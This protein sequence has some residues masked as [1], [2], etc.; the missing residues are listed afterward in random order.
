MRH[1]SFTGIL[2]SVLLGYCSISL[3]AYAQ[4]NQLNP[5]YFYFFNG[6][7]PG[8]WGLT[9]GDQTNWVLAVKDKQGESKDGQIEMTPAT[10][11]SSGDAIN[12]K[13]SRKKGKGQFAIYGS[14]IDLTSIEHRAALTMEVKVITRPKKALSIGVDCGYPCRGELQVHK[15]FRELPKEK[16]TTVPIPLDCFSVK[17]LDVSKI[18]APFLIATEGQLE[19]E[20]ANIRM[21]MLPEGTATCASQ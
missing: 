4:D 18:N 8:S 5:H 7:T 6:Q 12:L 21:E 13:W 16:W 19:I 20:L 15:M 1:Q 2:I 3:A 11:Q 9:L 10:Y 14:P 17:G